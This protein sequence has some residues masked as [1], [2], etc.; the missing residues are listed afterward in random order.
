L[1]VAEL[2]EKSSL[3]GLSGKNFDDINDAIAAA[4]NNA[5]A[6][7]LIMICGSFFV[8]AEMDFL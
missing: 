1:P 3:A 4:K 2:A 8:I 5:T 6:N 7:D